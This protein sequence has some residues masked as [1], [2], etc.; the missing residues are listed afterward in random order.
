VLVGAVAIG[1]IDQIFY[2]NFSSPVYFDGTLLL[3]IGGI[4]LLQQSRQSRAEQEATAGYLAARE[5]RPIP[6]E[7]RNLPVVDGWVR[8][9]GIIVAALVLGYP[10]VMSPAQVSLGSV[11]LIY[12]IIGLSLL[13]LTGWAGQIS[14]GQFALAA[15]GGYVAA[16]IAARLGLF[17]L[18]DL[19]VGGVA[20]AAIAALI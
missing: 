15:V 14:L 11:I 19:L 2:W 1:V 12:T 5:A 9:V 8:W 6:R 13:I 4:L 18:G 10:F 3:I 20:G 17:M 16:V 7:L